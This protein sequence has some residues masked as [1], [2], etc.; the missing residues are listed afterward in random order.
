[1]PKLG[2]YVL[3]DLHKEPIYVLFVGLKKLFEKRRQTD[4]YIINLF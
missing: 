1:M 4:N 3:C 2:L